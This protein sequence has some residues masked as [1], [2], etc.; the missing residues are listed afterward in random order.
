MVCIRTKPLKNNVPQGQ[1]IKLGTVPVEY[2]PYIE[3]SF[4]IIIPNNNLIALSISSSGD[5]FLYNY[6][7]TVGDGTS[8]IN[9]NETLT[10]IAN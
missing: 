3:P 4:R 6:N 8:V 9:S 7:V 1:N 2:R 10:Y 5:V